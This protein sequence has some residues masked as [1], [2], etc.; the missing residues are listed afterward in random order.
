[1][2]NTTGMKKGGKTKKM[3]DGG[4]LKEV[5]ADENPGLSKLPTNVRNKMGY[6]NQG[7]KPKKMNTG[8]TAC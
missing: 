7:G 5:D 2:G 6:M 1:M 4:S 3:A 8:G